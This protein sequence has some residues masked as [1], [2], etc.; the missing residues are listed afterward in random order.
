MAVKVVSE[1]QLPSTVHYL[2]Y[3]CFIDSSVSKGFCASKSLVLLSKPQLRAIRGTHHIPPPPSLTGLSFISFLELRICIF[4]P[5]GVNIFQRRTFLLLPRF[6]DVRPQLRLGDNK[7]GLH[8]RC[9]TE[10]H[11]A[12]LR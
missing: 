11:N 2:R 1:Q 3:K 10:A 7:Q 8:R 9:Q 4:S 12:L 5:M 6:T